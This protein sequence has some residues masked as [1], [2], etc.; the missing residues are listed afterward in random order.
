MKEQT[1]QFADPLAQA[2]KVNTFLCISTSILY[3]LS[4][5]IV[6]VSLLQGNRTPLYAISMLIVMIAT[7]VIGF[8]T[9]KKNSGSK[10]LRYFMMIGLVIVAGMLIYAYEDYYMRFLAI[11]PFLG[12]IFFFDLKFTRLAAVIVCAENVVFTL[13]RGLVLNNYS[14]EFFT[15]NLVAGVAVS[16]LMFLIHYLTKV[17]K[18]F[19][20]DSLG[21]VQHEAD[22]Q[23]AMMHDVLEI[24]ETI[25]MESNQASE[26]ITQL[27][28]SSEAAYQA[29][30]NI[31]QGTAST[32]ESIQHQSTMTQN[33]QSNLEHTL[34]RTENMVK[35]ATQSNTLNQSS[36][37]KITR[38]KEESEQLSST[39]DAVAEAMKHLQQNVVDVKEITKTIFSISSQT[40]LLALNASIESARAGEA[41]RGFAVVADEIRLLSEKT[42]QETEHISVILDNLS[43]NA[44]ETGRAIERSLEIGNTQKEMIRDIAIEFEEVN[45]NINELAIDIS[46]L[47]TTLNSLT[48][49]NTEIVN[50]ITTLSAVTE[51]VTASAQQSAE[52]SEINS[53]KAKTAKELLDQV[54]K[55][56]HQVDKYI[57]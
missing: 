20:E 53:E 17:A 26:I 37:A 45:T 51:E 36:A 10:S 21:K 3:L 4:Y 14:D 52:V 22:L 13:L 38:L 5:A 46:Q 30:D 33:I 54:I 2:K 7:I 19:N 28:E 50:E 47:G 48:T 15:P 39:N 16:V 32:A 56:S 57:Q 8:V 55:T 43:S 31:R 44:T 6:I 23:T 34:Q 35:A 41:G 40:N 25:R 12:S 24:A 1:F 11:M 9:L 27:Q 29:A 18:S 49:A 42:R